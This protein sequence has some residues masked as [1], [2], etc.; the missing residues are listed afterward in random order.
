[1]SKAG[2]ENK[3]TAEPGDLLPGTRVDDL[4]VAYSIRHGMSADILA[5][6]HHELNTP[7]VCK[8]LRA[9]VADAGKHRAR[10]RLEAEALAACAHP[11]VVRLI[12]YRGGARPYLLLEHVGEQTLR[13]L[14]LAEKRL[15]AEFAVRVVQHVGAALAHAHARGYL[16]RDVKPSNIVLRDGRPVLLDFGV[17]WRWRTRR[18]PADRSGTPQYLAPEQVRQE[19]LTPATDVWA[20]GA[21]LFELITGQRPFPPGVFAGKAALEECYPQLVAGVPAFRGLGCHSSRGLE[22][23]IRRCLAPDRAE[24]FAGATELMLALDP[25]TRT[26]I[27]P[28]VG[29]SASPLIGAETRAGNGGAHL[30]A[31]HAANAALA[32]RFKRP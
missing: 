27:W 28:R 10:L 2:G 30:T 22:G 9:D 25:F 26:K 16:H 6:W 24:R 3:L 21:L 32:R 17:A 19:K 12:E 1:M 29:R 11:G 4:T 8:R 18:R 20:L 23:V 7:L 14:L 5:V 13:D 15:W 31:R